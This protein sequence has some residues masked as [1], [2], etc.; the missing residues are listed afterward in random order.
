MIPIL[1]RYDLQEI[2]DKSLYESVKKIDY[3]VYRAREPATLKGRYNPLYNE[4]HPALG[5][6]DPVGWF[7]TIYKVEPTDIETVE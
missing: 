5:L 4:F 6:S 7:Y 2:I 3:L 1:K